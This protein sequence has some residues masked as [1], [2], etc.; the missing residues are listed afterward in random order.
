M[1]EV[2]TFQPFEVL[3]RL[4]PLG[5]VKAHLSRR[6]AARK[7]DGTELFQPELLVE[8]LAAAVVEPVDE[9]LGVEAAGVAGQQRQGLVVSP[10]VAVEGVAQIRDPVAHRLAD[11]VVAAQGAGRED[12]D[13]ELVVGQEFDLLGEGLGLPL[14]HQTAAPGRGHLQVH[15]LRRRGAGDERQRRHGTKRSRDTSRHCCSPPLVCRLMIHHESFVTSSG[16]PRANPAHRLRKT[17]AR[18]RIRSV[19]RSQPRTAMSRNALLSR[20]SGLSSS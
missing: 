19:N 2:R 12:L 10:V 16:V 8:L 4:H 5:A 20:A 7:R 13:L 9:L 1:P 3:Q 17:W 15:L 14:H 18:T 11:R 6:Y